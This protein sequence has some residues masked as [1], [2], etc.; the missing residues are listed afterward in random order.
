MSRSPLEPVPL[1]TMATPVTTPVATLPDDG[2]AAG[3]GE[4]REW[5]V[6]RAWLRREPAR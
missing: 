5:T 4:G 2:G 6:A 1:P 3:T